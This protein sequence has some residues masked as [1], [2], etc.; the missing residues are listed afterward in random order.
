MK[1]YYLYPGDAVEFDKEK[2]ELLELPLETKTKEDGTTEVVESIKVIAPKNWKKLIEENKFFKV[3][4]VTRQFTVDGVNIKFTK[5]TD[6]NSKEF[7]NR[8]SQSGYSQ[9]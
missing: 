3:K 6:E 4:L 9:A 7:F 1:D 5:V 8:M 2:E